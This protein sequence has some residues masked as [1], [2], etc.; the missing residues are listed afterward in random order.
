MISKVIYEDCKRGNKKLSIDWLDYQ[1]V[2]DSVPHSW[3]KKPK[4][5]VGV[6][7]K[8]VR[9]CKLSVEKWNTRLHLKTKQELMQLQPIQ[10]QR[11]IFHETSLSPLLFC[12]ARIPLTNQLNR[13]DCRYPVHGIE[14]KISHL[15]YMDDLKL[16]GRS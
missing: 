7:S 11:E 8:I 13:A 5:F 16:L 9:F 6:N 3:V 14:R 10:T 12:V 1:K 4:A 2:F 15:L